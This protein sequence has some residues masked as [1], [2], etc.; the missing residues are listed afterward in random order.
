MLPGQRLA[1]SG[2]KAYYM[3][4]RGPLQAVDGV[5]LTVGAGESLAIVGESGCGKSTLGGALMR[6][7]QLPGKILGG[8]ILLD[9]SDVLKMSS[10]EF[11]KKIRWKRVAMV[12][13]G[14]MN[15]LDPVYNIRSQMKE[16]LK[17]HRFEGDY[18]AKIIESLEQVGLD[19]KVASMYPHELSGGMK[20]RVVIAM[21]LILR[22]GLLIADEPT[23][24]LDVLVQ[25]DI[26]ELLKKTQN[27]HGV[28]II[29]ITHDLALVSEMATT[30]AIMCAGQIVEVAPA[31][32]LYKNPKHPYTRALISAIPRLNS[33]D[34]K[35][36][37]IPGSPPSLLHPPEGCRFRFRCPDVM[38]VCS[39]DPPE[40]R[41]D[42]GYVRCWLHEPQEKASQR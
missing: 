16:I 41:A 18:E 35:L 22:P 36:E 25:R 39:R 32:E 14:A 20:Q 23:T 15:T 3:T 4:E 13:Q 9:G 29:I 6:S 21:S 19:K 34:K 37:Y 27:D 42:S 5:N 12:F 24:A 7:L 40:I 2:L 10:A 1:V 38:D 33:R 8:T 11:D 17:V 31:S 26:I 28:S 30:I